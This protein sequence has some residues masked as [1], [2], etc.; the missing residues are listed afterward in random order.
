M[1]EGDSFK[2]EAARLG[3]K[4]QQNLEEL[5]RLGFLRRRRLRGDYKITAEGAPYLLDVVQRHDEVRAQQSRDAERWESGEMTEVQRE[6]MQIELIFFGLSRDMGREAEE[7]LD[8]SPDPAAWLEG[9]GL[10]SGLLRDEDWEPLD[11]EACRVTAFRPF[12]DAEEDLR[13][14]YAAIEIESPALAEPTIGYITNQLDFQHVSEAFEGRGTAD[15]KEVIVVWSKS[16]L[17]AAVG[18]ASRSLP[19]L[20]VW[21]CPKHAYEIATDPSFRPDLGYEDRLDATSPIGRWESEELR[22]IRNPG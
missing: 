12:P 19:G 20:V 9:L 6:R 1:S 4:Y 16:N 17:Q 21:L 11:G 14:P 18:P 15:D 3:P 5:R 22:A 10:E 13:L 2:E 7:A 8:E